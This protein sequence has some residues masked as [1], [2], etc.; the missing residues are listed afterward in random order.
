M[1]P[2]KKRLS[3]NRRRLCREDRA[4]EHQQLCLRMRVEDRGAFLQHDHQRPASPKEA[5]SAD[6]DPGA[7]GR[8]A[9]KSLNGQVRDSGCGGAVPSR[10]LIP[11][12]APFS[13][14]SPSIG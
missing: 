4:S 12:A 2:L 1:V 9:D 8:V 7:A 14:Q 6:V 13:L 11:A 10:R 5:M 3:N